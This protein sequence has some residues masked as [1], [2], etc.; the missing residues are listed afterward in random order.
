MMHNARA[1]QALADWTPFAQAQL[2]MHTQI[3]LCPGWN[4]GQCPG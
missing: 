2:T 3:V 4:D 1:G